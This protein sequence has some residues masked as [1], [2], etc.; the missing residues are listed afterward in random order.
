MRATQF[1]GITADALITSGIGLQGWAGVP[2]QPRFAQADGDFIGGARLFWRQ[3]FDSEV[4]ASYV[5]ALRKGYVAR[6]DFALDGSWTPI[7]PVTVSGLAQW[8]LEES[9]LQEAKVQALWQVNKQVQLVGDIQRTAPD[10]FIDRSSIFRGLLGG[11]PQR[12]WR[13]RSCTV[14]CSP[15]SLEADYHWLNVEAGHGYRMGARAT[16]R[17]P[18]GGSYGAELRLLDEPDNGYRWRGSSASASCGT[19]SPSRSISTPTG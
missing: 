13:P 18:Y 1:D 7:R 5:Y 17:T 9:R 3:A 6:N 19:T 8:S 12:S 10:L 2:V 4:G 11:V 14:R 15:L 16:Y